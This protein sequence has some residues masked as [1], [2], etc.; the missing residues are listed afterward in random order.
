MTSTASLTMRVTVTNKCVGPSTD[1][2]F[3][4]KIHVILLLYIRV[5]VKC[6]HYTSD[7]LLSVDNIRRSACQVLTVY[8]SDCYRTDQACRCTASRHGAG[9]EA[10]AGRG[11]L[12]V[13]TPL[14]A[15][16]F[17]FRPVAARRYMHHAQVQTTD[18][19]HYQAGAAGATVRW[20]EGSRGKA[21]GV[22]R[23]IR[24]LVPKM[25]IF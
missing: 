22:S 8:P 12:H 19:I 10:I 25:Q 14:A 20:R 2:V 9:N 17:P 4:C 16:H 24:K 18:R 1:H 5:L 15:R 13:S 21:N 11:L 23:Q 3:K 7:S 6:W